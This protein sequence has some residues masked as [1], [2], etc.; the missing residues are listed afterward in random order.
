[1]APVIKA[2]NRRPEDS[3]SVVR[4]TAQ[5]REMLDQMLGVLDIVPDQ[6]PNVMRPDQSLSELTARILKALGAVV[7]VEQPGWVLVQGDTTTVMVTSL[8]AFY[9][10]AKPGHVEGRLG[11]GDKY[12]PYPEEINRRLTDVLADLH[13]APVAASRDTVLR[14]G[15]PD[16]VII[17]TGN[18]AI[19][20]VLMM[21]GHVDERSVRAE[22][23]IV[24]AKSI[25]P[26]TPH[27]HESCGVPLANV[28]GALLEIARRYRERF[29]LEYLVHLGP[30]VR[31]LARETLGEVPNIPVIEPMDDQTFVGLLRL[32]YTVLTDSDGLQ[33]EIPS[34]GKPVPVLREVTERPEGTPPGAARLVGTI[35]RTIVW[36]MVHLLDNREAYE[37]LASVENPYGDGRAAEKIVRSIVAEGRN[38]CALVA[39]PIATV[40]A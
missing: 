37:D 38:P 9:H 16:T 20:A 36:E 28:F 18:T 29:D 19:G 15:V 8:V 35:P 34:L 27:R 4:V 30:S 24:D 12:S 10:G 25:I 22:T 13:F 6:D 5:H 17:V 11:T 3:D 14:E 23:G 21:A 32:A 33:E 1:M 39:Q 2:L 40:A 7:A 31:T 26:D